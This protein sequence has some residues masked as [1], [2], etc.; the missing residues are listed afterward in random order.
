MAAPP[1]PAASPPPASAVAAALLLATL[2]AAGACAEP[3]CEAAAAPRG[4]ATRPARPSGCRTVEPG[5]ALAGLL[6]TAPPGARFCLE[7]GVHQGPLRVGSEITI[8]GPAEAVVL[9]SGAGTT[10][11]VAGAGVAL[12]GFT[13]DGSGGRYDK[14]DAAVHVQGDGVRVEGLTVRNAV[15]GILVERSRRAVIRGNTV[16]GDRAIAIGLR[17]D[18]I[19]LWETTDSLIESNQ[20]TDGRD[21]VIW[22]SSR[23]QLRGNR[24]DGGRYGAHLMYSHDNVVEDNLF[25]GGVV[26]VFVMYSRNVALRR[27]LIA[28]AAGAA[29]MGIGLKDSG[30]ITLEGNLFLH[31]AVGLYIDS[32]PM[33]RGDRNRI[34]GNVFRLCD[35]GVVFH[36]GTRDTLFRDNDFADNDLQVRVDGGG[37]ATEVTWERNYFDDY[38]GYDLDADG[39]GDLPYELRS[40]SSELTRRYPNLAFF[41]GAPALRLAD[42]ASHMVPLLQP[43]ILL[44]DPAPRMDPHPLEM[45]H[46][47]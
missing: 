7:P 4:A 42:A 5:A 36:A 13:I 32:S 22:Y 25:R 40:L 37:N 26:G 41:R 6:A 18:S 9:S 15:Y 21:V 35:T 16:S 47:H 29:G 12:L 23:N 33:Q 3:T 17:G 39:A 38:A 28:D 45:P 30:N 11:A 46:A 10:I 44:R 1:P 8:W 20:V 27:N 19:R 43:R 2:A 24:I 34:T 14:L 31:D